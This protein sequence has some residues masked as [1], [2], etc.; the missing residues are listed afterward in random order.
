VAG[1][2]TFTPASIVIVSALDAELSM[3]I[4]TNE[5]TGIGLP[6]ILNVKYAATDPLL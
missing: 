2:L 5:P 4:D 6:L 1:K 3:R